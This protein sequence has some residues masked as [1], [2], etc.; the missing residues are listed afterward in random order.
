MTRNG[1]YLQLRR[2]RLPLDRTRIM[3]ILNV[4]PDSFYDGGRYQDTAA[5]VEQARK[6]VA[7]G[8]DILDIGGESS[9]PGSEPVSAEEELERVLP[10]IERVRELTDIPLS[11]DTWKASVARTALRAG[12]DLV[13][14]ISSFRFDPEM[15]ATL[16]E[17]GAGIV[18][19]HMRGSPKT[20][21]QLPPSPDILA[22]IRADIERALELASNHQIPRDRI[23]LDPGIG[24]GKSLQENLRILNRLDFLRDF[25]LPVLVGTSRKS[26]L[27]KILGVPEEERLWGTAASTAL[28]VARGADIIRVHDV[29]EM[30]MVA[31]V[32]EAIR[33]ERT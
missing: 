4:T 11:V 16:A 26:F 28:A 9:R 20:M 32:A 8:A 33:R 29:R 23:V 3:G 1:R 6:M 19:M 14:D 27:G 25:S 21:Q 2:R 12:V 5:A 17:F 31:Q 13:N 10:V 30:G 18:L 24:F 15:P 7:E 22:E